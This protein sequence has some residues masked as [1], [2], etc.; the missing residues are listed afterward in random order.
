MYNNKYRVL[1]LTNNA[2]GSVA[3]TNFM[4]LGTITRRIMRCEC[5]VNTFNTS[6]TGTNVI[7]INEAGNYDVI[8]NASLIAAAAGVVIAT[9]VVNGVNVL[10]PRYSGSV[11]R[12]LLGN[13]PC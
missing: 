12:H 1:Q 10:Y 11:L 8:Y 6:T 9:V 7:S 5:N 2:I 3:V 13:Q 4:P